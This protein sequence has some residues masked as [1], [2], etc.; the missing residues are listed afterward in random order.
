MSIQFTPDTPA[1]RQ[2]FNRLAR[3]KMKLRL[4][5]DI[6]MDLMVCELEGYSKLEY[7][8]ELL[9]LVQ[10]LRKKGGRRR[11]ME[12]TK[13]LQTI[14]RSLKKIKEAEF[15]TSKLWGKTSSDKLNNS[16]YIIESMKIREEV[17][18]ALDAVDAIKAEEFK[19]LNENILP[20]LCEQIGTDDLQK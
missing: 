17:K 4:L 5:A 6:R 2:A 11:E 15:R 8:D 9:A 20:L 7:L 19:F 13:N 1:T 10:E 12:I 14:E 18:K 16:L 3:E